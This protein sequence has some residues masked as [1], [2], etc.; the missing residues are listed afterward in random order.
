MSGKIDIQ[1]KDI[2]SISVIEPVTESPTVEKAVYDSDRLGASTFLGDPRR[3]GWRPIQLNYP[4]HNAGHGIPTIIDWQ[5]PQCNLPIYM[6]N[7]GR[8][9]CMKCGLPVLEFPTIK[10]TK[11]DFDNRDIRRS[12]KNWMDNKLNP[13]ED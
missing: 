4:G 7:S 8:M 10:L 11:I 6:A 12:W 2:N 5:C 1:Q 3:G 13:D 9:K